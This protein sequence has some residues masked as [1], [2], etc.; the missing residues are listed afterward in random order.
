MS[1]THTSTRKTGQVKFF[2][3]TKGYGFIV[4]KEQEGSDTVEDVFVHHTSIKN[5]GGFRSLCQ[6]E[7]VEYDLI[8]GPKG[9]QATLVTGIG[10]GPVK[11]DL[12]DSSQRHGRQSQ[13]QGHRHMKQYG[14][15][16]K[17]HQHQHYHPE[18][19][20]SNSYYQVQGYHPIPPIYVYHHQHHHHPS[21]HH[22]SHHEAYA[23]ANTAPS[24]SAY[25]P[26]PPSTNHPPAIIHY[27]LPSN[28]SIPFSSHP[29]PLPSSS[30]VDSKTESY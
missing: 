7:E 24:A 16:Q 4:S 11:G 29:M 5:D 9:M 14:Y 21:Y 1:D 30:P 15:Q 2:N 26:S 22:Y 6:D 8:K 20:N 17:R 10:G 19:Y 12:V 28:S 27:S 23:A 3:S 25:Y 18:Y 13:Y